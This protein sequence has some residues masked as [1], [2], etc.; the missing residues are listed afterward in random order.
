MELVLETFKKNQIMELDFKKVNDAA[1]VLRAVRNPLR[2]K[3]LAVL[4]LT[5]GINV[6]E[7]FMKLQLEQSVASQH[8][9]ILRQAG[10]VRTEREGKNI[11]Y[12][13]DYENIKKIS[14]LVE[15]LAVFY[16]G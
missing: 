9:A 8:L 5:P 1:M 7:L 13:I 12:S 4:D 2:K 6:T 10:I 11:R 14:P 3:I 16:K 15:Q